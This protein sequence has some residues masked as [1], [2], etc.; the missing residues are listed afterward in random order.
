MQDRTFL[1]GL[2]R[3]ATALLQPFAS[4]LLTF[5]RRRGKEDAGRLAER[6]GH[7][8]LRRPDG[9]LAWL[10]GASL[11]ETV[12]I[13]PVV[14]RLTRRGFSVLVTSGTLTSA[15]LLMRR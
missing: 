6:R 9:R 11:G 8:S 10:H 4:G 14:E 1:L 3:S 13:L 2:Y 15:N 12:S 5:R 7:A